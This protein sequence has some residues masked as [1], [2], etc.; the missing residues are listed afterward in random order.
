MANKFPIDITAQDKFSA[1]FDKLNK[2]VANMTR[3]VN[4]LA[5]S[6]KT[7]AEK[8]GLNEISK[9][10]GELRSVAS[11]AGRE[12]GLLAGPMSLLGGGATIAGIAAMA[13]KWGAVGVSLTNVS[14]AS[15]VAASSLSRMQS[16]ARLAGASAD[17]VTSSMQGLAEITN[18]ATLGRNNL[19]LA[20]LNQLNIHLARTK[21]GLVDTR[22]EF[23]DLLD[24]I[25]AQPNPQAQNLIARN[26]GIDPSLL[27]A[28]V[29]KRGAAAWTE[30]EEK[31]KKRGDSLTPGQVKDANELSE[32]STA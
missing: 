14:A 7:L 29:R 6:T 13:D 8:S 28:D 11:E 10:F 25:A 17:A 21:D 23:L 27:T 24:A 15:G 5:K 20:T 12:L 31:A 2:S 32:S 26:M 30:R 3:P 22:K 9:S 4:E 19:A 16:A 18:D 1:V